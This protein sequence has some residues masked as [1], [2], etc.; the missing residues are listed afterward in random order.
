M[1]ID[2]KLDAILAGQKE[3][4]AR[5][6]RIL[7]GVA[8]LV[9]HLGAAQQASGSSSNGSA[10]GRVAADVDLDSPLNNPEVKK[11]PPRWKKAGL[12]GEAPRRM[13]ECSP[14]Y[15]DAVAEFRDFCADN[16]QAGKERYAGDDRREAQLARGWAARKR[17]GW[18]PPG[19]ESTPLDEPPPPDEL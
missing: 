9:K 1:T 3:A 13:A 7:R 5:E 19:E 2:E 11:D 14:A 15:L 18:R 16:P 17:A 6:E 10:S 4:A 8:L 12:D